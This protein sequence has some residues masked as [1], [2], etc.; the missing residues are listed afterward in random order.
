MKFVVHVP[1][2]DRELIAELTAFPSAE[3]VEAQKSFVSIAGL[4]FR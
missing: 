2:T 3:R 4:S 1:A